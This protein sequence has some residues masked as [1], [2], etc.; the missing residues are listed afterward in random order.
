MGHWDKRTAAKENLRLFEAPETWRRYADE[1]D[2]NDNSVKIPGC[3]AALDRF[4]VNGLNSTNILILTGAGA[5]F[6]V[7]NDAASKLPVRTAPGL[8]D[9]WKAVEEKVG[10]DAL[11]TILSIIPNPA[12][13]GQVEKLLTQCK[14][15]VA[16]FGDAAGNG[17]K[18]SEFIAKAE[19][20]ILARVDFVDDSTDV[21]PHEI[22]LRKFARRG[23]RKP[24]AKVFTTNY[25]LCFE[26]AARRSRFIVVDGFS[27]AIP[28][29]YDRSHFALDIV[30]RD[31]TK[32]APDYLESVFQ[33]YKLH[34]SIDWRRTPAEIIR[35][36]GSEG[37]P[38]LI[39]PRDS[40]YQEAFEPPYLDMMGAFQTSLREPDTALFVS[41]FSFSDSH[42]SA[43]VLAALESNMNFRMVVCDPILL[44]DDL[45]KGDPVTL[46]TADAGFSK[47]DFHRRLMRLAQSGDQRLMLLHG[48]FEDL[49][50]ALP[51]L[52][53][54][55][56]RERH[57]A[58]VRVLR[59]AHL[60][61]GGAPL[62]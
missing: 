8:S 3:A 41:G 19:N 12:A 17:K 29:V 6:C 5:S 45:V 61:G 53:A 24:R 56:E 2:S 33:L 21:G 4:L 30:R 49:A 28:Q 47:N 16:L 38:V 34:G 39:Y 18:V 23:I 10:A 25:D 14:L 48:R 11:K 31:S 59:D 13:T 27:H 7:K 32:E 1:I 15:Y 52:V 58:R 40:K 35:A 44:T 20:A 60:P 43:P 54:E 37:Q 55:T 42:I 50:I 46:Q 26:Y 57:A 51:D 9:L 62:P 22:L 36:R